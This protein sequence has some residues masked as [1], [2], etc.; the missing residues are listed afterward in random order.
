[1]KRRLPRGVYFT[2]LM[3]KIHPAASR[4]AIA[5]VVNNN[6]KLFAKLFK[7]LAPRRGVT[8]KGRKIGVYMTPR[9]LLRLWALGNTLTAS[10]IS[11]PKYKP[12]PVPK[13]AAAV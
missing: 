12:K 8:I 7:I 9:S 10:A 11:M 6:E 4:L 2:D 1:M 5:A 13:S 3:G